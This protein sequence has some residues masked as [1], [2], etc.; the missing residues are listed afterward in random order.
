MF[1]TQD[2]DGSLPV[3]LSEGVPTVILE[4]IPASGVWEPLDEPMHVADEPD[5]VVH[6]QP[7]KS[8]QSNPGLAQTL[9]RKDVDAGHLVHLPGG[10]SAARERWGDR[11]AAGKF[12]LLTA[13]GKKT[14]IDR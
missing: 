12:G 9:L 11:L 6:E 10:E 7:W 2:V 8:A 5:L 3:V 13:P 14:Q 4:P 1:R